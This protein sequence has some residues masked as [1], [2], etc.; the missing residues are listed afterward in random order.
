MAAGTEEPIVWQGRRT[1]AFVPSLLA[2]RDLQ[3]DPRTAASAA[4][5][6]ADLAHGAESLPGDYAPLARLLLRAEGVASSFIE[7]VRASVVDVVLAEAAPAGGPTPAAWVAANLAAVS[8]A[9]EH[10][11][12]TACVT[13][14][15]VLSWHKTLM[16]GSPIPARYIG[17]L[18]TEQGWIGGTSPLDAHLVTPP[19]H[20]LGALLADLLDYLNRSDGD[21]VAQAAVGHAQFEVIHPFADGNGRVGR[22]LVGWVLTRRL[23]L[24]AAPPVSAA[25]AADVGGYTAGLTQ[26]RL[27]EH[28]VWIRWFAQAVS[29][30]AQ[31]QRALVREVETI[32]RGWEEA[33]RARPRG[34]VRRDAVAWRVLSLLPRHLVLTSALVADL[35]GVTGKA[36]AD[37]LVTLAEAG[38]LTEHG[39]APQIGAG[40]PK[41]LF[42]SV[43]LLGLAGASPLR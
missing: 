23:G 21:P 24:L 38:V 8:D 18:R 15:L 37:A 31:A 6:V 2:A 33:L 39:T 16:S 22:V 35:L 27:G 17:A 34:P 43:D 5:A 29:G 14:E 9:A 25:I 10:A 26:F 20:H 1:R 4:T 42:V 19:P 36:A 30:A 13:Q 3:L 28:G 11:A 41:R 40:R 32:K 7:G 12:G